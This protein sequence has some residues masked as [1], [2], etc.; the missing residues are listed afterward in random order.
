M[1]AHL[2]HLVTT[3]NVG[4]TEGQLLAL[5]THL[6]QRVWKSSL[7]CFRPTGAFVPAFRKTGID[8]T[9]L[10]LFGTL[11]RPNTLRAVLRLARHLRQTK[12]ALLH[13]HDVYAALIGIPAGRLAGVPT[14]ASRRDLGHHLGRAQRMGLRLVLGRADAVVTNAAAVAARVHAEEGVP[15]GRLIVVPNGLDVPAF[16][17]A[18]LTVS[19]PLPVANPTVVT[20]ARMTHP[21]KGHDDLLEAA[22]LVSH[23]APHIRFLVVGDGPRAPELY[24]RA[25]ELELGST[26]VFAGRRDDVPALLTRSTLVCHPAR[27]E[28]FPNAV[29][30]AMAARRA[31][32]ATAAGG[33]PALLENGRYGVVVPTADPPALARAMLELLGNPDQCLRLGA[34]ARAHVEGE[35]SL[36]RLVER[37]ERVYRAMK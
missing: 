14:L 7:V 23:A 35:F 27:A 10:P 2:V 19:P 36:E 24:R 32:V 30:E 4:G 15:A 26:V 11:L 6:D 3:L 17:R 16:D 20:V 1:R 37:M 18:A 9:P 5:L 21:A 34:A 29:L 8:I 22:S 13:C 28:G 25:R 33:V 31:I 12:A